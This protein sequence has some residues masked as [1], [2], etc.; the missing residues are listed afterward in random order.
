M[1]FNRGVERIK[2]VKVQG[3][4]NAA[5][6]ALELF[7]KQA[8]SI[9][10]NDKRVLLKTLNNSKKVLSNARANEPMLRNIL[11]IF[12]NTIPSLR[13]KTV[14]LPV[15]SNHVEQ[16]CCQIYQNRIQLFQ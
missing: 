2:S 1:S 12:Y 9:R 10:T 5:L 6:Y 11:E 16:E 4:T 14:F 8:K 7:V 13:N 15:N 3:A